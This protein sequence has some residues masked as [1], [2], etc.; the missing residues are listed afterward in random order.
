MAQLSVCA[1]P[2]MMHHLRSVLEP[3]FSARG[4]LMA[5]LLRVSR[6]TFNVSVQIKEKSVQQRSFDSDEKP[7]AVVKRGS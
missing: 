1:F 7:A 3:Q 4:Q 6:V 2:L 5:W